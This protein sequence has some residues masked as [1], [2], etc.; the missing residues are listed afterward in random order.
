M[1]AYGPNHQVFQYLQSRQAHIAQHGHQSSTMTTVDFLTHVLNFS[2]YILCRVEQVSSKYL[3]I[4]F[5][6]LGHFGF[7]STRRVTFFLVYTK[8]ISDDESSKDLAVNLSVNQ[9]L[10]S[11]G[12]QL[13]DTKRPKC[14]KMDDGSSLQQKKFD[15]VQ[16]Q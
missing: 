6:F 2:M 5:F 9:K 1:V 14:M 16:N 10:P 12:Q 11:K 15:T 13:A 3:S 7:P 4:L 8:A